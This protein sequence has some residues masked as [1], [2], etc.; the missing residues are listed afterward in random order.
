MHV[1]CGLFAC[2]SHIHFLPFLCSALDYRDRTLQT[3]LLGSL[4]SV[5][6]LL[7]ATQGSNRKLV[8]RRKAE[9]RVSSPLTVWGS[10]FS[11]GCV[12]LVVSSPVGKLPLLFQSLLEPWLPDSGDYVFPPLALQPRWQGLLGMVN[13][14][15]LL[16]SFWFLCSAINFVFVFLFWFGLV[17]A[18]LLL[19]LFLIL[20]K[21]TQSEVDQ[22]DHFSAHSSVYIKSAFQV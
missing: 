3:A 22:F 1:L 2:F 12:S 6:L 14:L 20:V 13:L 4:T 18:A 11:S 16:I 9:A 8:V 21:Y 10:V 17:S 7:L 19:L 5:F 15:L